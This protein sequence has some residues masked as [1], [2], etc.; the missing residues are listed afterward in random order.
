M[1]NDISI[2]LK[3]AK[4]LKIPSKFVQIRDK[5]YSSMIDEIKSLIPTGMNLYS[6]YEIFTT[7]LPEDLVILYT[8]VQGVSEEVLNEINGFN[9]SLEISK[10]RDVAE[11]KLLIQ[12]W[13]R[14]Y[15][16]E[17]EEIDFFLEI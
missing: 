6:L 5:K 15:V 13:N 2:L 1:D 10:I 11:L 4:R 14:K 7:I 3:E 12:D 9:T 16:A 8:V 17:F